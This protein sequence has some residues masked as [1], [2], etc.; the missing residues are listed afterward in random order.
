MIRTIKF[1][2]ILLI[3]GIALSCQLSAQEII[4]LSLDGA[5][6]YALENNYDIIN[7][8]KDVEISE[9]Q[10]AA[11]MAIGFPQ[12]NAVVDYTNFLELPTSLIPAEFFGGEPGDFI[13]VSFGTEHNLT[14]DLTLTQLIFSGSYIVG[15]QAAKE[16]VDV[17]RKMMI[18][19]ETE[20][21]EKVENAYYVVLVTEETLTIIDSTLASL[22][23]MQWEI[24]E[25]FKQ[26]FVEDTDVDQIDLLVSDLE[27]TSINIVKQLQVA[28]NYL[29][30]I[31]GMEINQP[32][33]LT[34][35]LESLITVLDEDALLSDKFDHTR[36]INYQLIQGRQHLKEYKLK[37]E[38]AQYLPSMV[39]FVSVSENAQR[40]SFDFYESN[41]PWFRTSLWGINLSV[42]IFSSGQRK[43]NVQKAKLELEQIHVM[44][45]QVR[46]GLTL[47]FETS[48]S[49]YQNALAVYAQNKKNVGIADKIY[50]K[51]MLKYSEGVSSSMDLLQS[52]NQYLNSQSSY[53]S[54][55][56][57]L[58]GAKTAL[59]KVLTKY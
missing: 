43:N 23:K 24:Q 57:D 33:I 56:V 13:E 30:F 39:G 16:V 2:I 21:K 42:P 26:G 45:E 36:N 52:Y 37:N 10:V 22:Y 48:R 9:K 31:L 19:N 35:D 28:K 59:E 58:L 32:I 25:T 47:E 15:L 20:L 29:K 4:R 5:V 44:D 34:D 41:Q 1:K 11:T 40:T 18:K 38:K 50:R 17:S 8:N 51:T 46:E 55:M 12:I 6:Q 27:A 54:A 14:A 7:P 3:A 49:N 53:I